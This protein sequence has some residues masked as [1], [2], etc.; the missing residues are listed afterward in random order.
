MNNQNL[1]RL[2][3]VGA[4]TGGP[5]ALRLLVAGLEPEL[6]AAVLIVQH[7]APDS[8]GMLPALLER[9][10]RLPAATARDG[11]PILAGR[12]LLPPPQPPSGGAGGR[13]AWDTRARDARPARKSRPPLHRRL[14]PLGSSCLQRPDDRRTEPFR[15]QE[16]GGWSSLALPRRYV[17]DAKVANEGVELS[18]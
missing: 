7:L 6:P 9:A 10:G 13:R 11:E 8:P 5:E 17:E 4:S 3:V 1:Q 12:I 14:V 18:K 2:I 16:A 15:L